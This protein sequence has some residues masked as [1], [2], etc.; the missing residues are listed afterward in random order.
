MPAWVADGCVRDVQAGIFALAGEVAD[1]A[2]DLPYPFFADGH[3]RRA[4]IGADDRLSSLAGHHEIR[5]RHSGERKWLFSRL[6]LRL[7]YLGEGYVLCSAGDV[8]GRLLFS[9]VDPT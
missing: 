2:C 1:S 4:H 6:G 8:V 7:R 5:V 9:Y 3:F